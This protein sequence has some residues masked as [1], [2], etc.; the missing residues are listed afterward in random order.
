M[1]MPTGEA[2]PTEAPAQSALDSA[3]EEGRLVLEK[4]EFPAVTA[5]AIEIADEV[6]DILDEKKPADPVSLFSAYLSETAIAWL[7]LSPAGNSGILAAEGM[8]GFSYY[9]GKYHMFYPSPTRGVE[10][11]YGNLARMFSSLARVYAGR[12]VTGLQASVGREGVI[13]SPDGRYAAILNCDSTIQTAQYYQDPVVI[14]LSTGEMILTTTYADK[15]NEEDV[16]AVTTGAFSADG[17]YLYYMVFGKGNEF[18]TA[19]YRYDFQEDQTELCYSGSD[20]HYYPHLV[21]IKDGSFLILQDVL[22]LG[23]IQGITRIAFENG[24]WTGAD[25]T[26]DLPMPYWKCKELLYS[27]RSGY[28]LVPGECNLLSGV[29]YAFQ[30]VRPD[31]DFAGLNRYCSI[32]KADGQILAMTADEISAQVD[33]WAN[34]L[35]DSGKSVSDIYPE[36][37]FQTIA[38][39]AMSPDGRYA[40]LLTINYGTPENPTT[41]RHLYLVRLDDLAVREVAGI[42]PKSIPLSALANYKPMIEWNT[43]TLLIG[44]SDGV[45]AYR[46]RP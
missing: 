16:G 17:R 31:E 45:Q 4:A 30:C 14:D 37:P 22:N 38:K 34:R 26:F 24:A 2:E 1:P 13:Y 42:D 9:D 29:N 40:L 33:T 3:F 44:T 25:R 46:F 11:A 6:W 35:K 36:I 19:L 5:D 15:L 39:M 32:S 23:E 43:D 20:F 21:E 12:N 8:P 10:D 7:S 28:A 27:A 41:S 18:R